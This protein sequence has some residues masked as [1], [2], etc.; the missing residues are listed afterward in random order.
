MGAYRY[1][2][3]YRL[4]ELLRETGSTLQRVDNVLTARV[5]IAMMCTIC[6]HTFSASPHNLAQGTG[7]P[8][9]HRKKGSVKGVYR[10]NL[11]SVKELVLSYGWEVVDE[12]YRNV[13]YKLTIKC[14]HCGNIQQR[15]FSVLK[16]GFTRCKQCGK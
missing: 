8:E 10:H 15:S 2:D 5:S 12:Q 7:C 1:W 16:R 11:E 4:D 6:G 13:H 14:I 3:N 9:C